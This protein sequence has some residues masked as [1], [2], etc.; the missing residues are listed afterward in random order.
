MQE[1]TEQILE[2]ENAKYDLIM[3]QLAAYLSKFDDETVDRYVDSVL[4]GDTSDEKLLDFLEKFGEKAIQVRLILEV[5]TRLEA[6]ETVDE[7]WVNE[8]AKQQLDEIQGVYNNIRSR[9][10]EAVQN[11]N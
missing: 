8:W 5:Q 3:D 2:A 6:G 1:R 7:A 11:N 9:V 4:V 10:N